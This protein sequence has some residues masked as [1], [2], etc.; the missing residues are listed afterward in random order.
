MQ[1]VRGPDRRVLS[2]VVAVHEDVDVLADRSVLVEDPTPDIGVLALERL[3]H[4]G[5]GRALQLELTF[6]PGELRQRSTK[7]H[8]R[9]V[10][11]LVVSPRTPG[12]IRRRKQSMHRSQGWRPN[13]GYVPDR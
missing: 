11:I 8:D 10:S 5:D 3:Q 2:P 12:L 9:H 4:L 1:P 7:P 6:P 13:S